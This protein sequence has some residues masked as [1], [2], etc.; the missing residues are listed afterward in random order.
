[1]NNALNIKS[2]SNTRRVGR[3][4]GRGIRIVLATFFFLNLALGATAGADTNIPASLEISGWHILADSVVLDIA[5][6]STELIG[7]VKITR[8]STVIAADDAKIFT[9]KA[10]SDSGQELNAASI[11]KFI[12]NGNVRIEL[13]N[14]V[15]TSDKADYEAASKIIVLSGAPAKFIT[16]KNTISASV[17]NINFENPE[18]TVTELIGNAAINQESTAISADHIKVWTDNKERNDNAEPGLNRDS[19]K[20]LEANG[21]VRIV[22]DNGVATSEKAVYDAETK[23]FIISG[24]GTKFISGKNPITAP[25]I[26]MNRENGKVTFEGTNHQPVEAVIFPDDKK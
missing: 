5:K 20:K 1:M 14:G 24:T 18:I 26:T 4:P 2:N 19:I 17:L 7:N 21:N 9:S 15:A 11:D 8:E 10:P 12:A 3:L 16:G 6:S 13:E 22:L 23:R 25:V